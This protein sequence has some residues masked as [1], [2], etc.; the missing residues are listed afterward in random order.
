M[1]GRVC[2]VLVVSAVSVAALADC[3]PRYEVTAVVHGPDCGWPWGFASV[4]P[5]ALNDLGHIAGD[6]A[7]PTADPD[8]FGWYGEG[9]IVP[10]DLPPGSMTSTGEDINS[11]DWIVGTVDIKDELGWLAF[12]YDGKTTQT[13]GVLPGANCSRGQAINAAGDVAG[14][15]GHNVTADPPWQAFL[16]RDGEMIN[17]G[18]QMGALKSRAYDIS[19]NGEVVGYRQM[20]EDG[21]YM[22]FLWDPQ[23]VVDLGP[24]EGGYSSSAYGINNKREVVG[25]G[26]LTDEGTGE[27]EKHAFYWCDGQMHDLGTLPP[28]ENSLAYDI[29]DSSVIVGYCSKPSPLLSRAF[30]WADGVM[31]DLNELIPP[32]SGVYLQNARD[33]NNAG[34]IVVRGNDELSNTVAVLLTPIDLPPT[35]LDCD[36]ITGVVDLLILLGEWGKTDSPADFNQDGIVN[37][38]DLLILLWHWG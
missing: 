18:E 9:P 38:R 1:S 31:W 2:A 5:W 8:A 35:D 7:C 23:G 33:I 14:F 6:W 13:L 17:L 25:S 37:V 29:N 4:I 24:I 26:L 21:Q 27:T 15:S 16:W 19:A 28:Y 32:D 22:A 36:G 34:Q 12:V 3:P 11:A 20:E 30:V 10:V